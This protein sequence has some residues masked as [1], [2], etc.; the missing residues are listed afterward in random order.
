MILT[1]ME[2]F[3]VKEPLVKLLQEKFP[4]KVSYGLVKTAQKLEAQLQIIEKV[5]QGLFQTYGEPDKNDPTQLRLNPLSANYS[6]GMAELGE[7]MTQ[8]VEIVIEV[9]TL[10]DTLEIEPSISMA[11][12][13]FVKV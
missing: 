10:P 3:N 11:L 2:I 9:V 6:K 5:R 13:K 8:E 12:D 4:V 1:N 7:L